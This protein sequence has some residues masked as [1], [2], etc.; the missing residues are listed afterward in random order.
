VGLGAQGPHVRVHADKLQHRAGAP[1]LHAHNEGLGKPLGAQ[2]RCA[3]VVGAGEARSG[4][5]GGR[6]RAGR[7]PGGTAG[8][9]LGEKFLAARTGA[10]E[11][12]RRAQEAAAAEVVAAAQEAVTQVSAGQRQREREEQ[13]ACPPRLRWP[14]AAQDPIGHGSMGPLR[15]TWFP[16]GHLRQSGCG[17]A[18]A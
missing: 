15:G 6:G 17:A 8:A 16:R 7:W 10:A 11:A 18:V 9:G 4:S 14:R 12:A 1:L 5:G 3:R 2:L 13:P